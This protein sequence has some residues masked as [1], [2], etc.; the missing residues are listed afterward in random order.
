MREKKASLH[1]LEAVGRNA[2]AGVVVKA[3]PVPPFEVPQSKFLLQFLVV[4]LDAPTQPCRGGQAT[5]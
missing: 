4:A 2:E 3:A 1:H 5:R